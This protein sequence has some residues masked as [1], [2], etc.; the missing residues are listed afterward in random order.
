MKQMVSS[1]STAIRKDS[2]IYVFERYSKKE[3]MISLFNFS[4]QEQVYE[5]HI[6]DAQKLRELLNSNL[7][8]YG[9]TQ[10]RKSASKGNKR[11]QDRPDPASHTLLFIILL[12]NIINLQGRNHLTVTAALIIF[13]FILLRK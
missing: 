5:L 3:R 4:D 1:G 11:R 10:K 9:G 13:F 6:S 8:V 12:N 7:A 2:C